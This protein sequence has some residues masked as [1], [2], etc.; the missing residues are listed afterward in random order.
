[1][2]SEQ[3]EN[4]TNNVNGPPF[5]AEPCPAGKHLG[6]LR[7]SFS[8]ATTV[9]RVLGRRACSNNKQQSLAA[10]PSGSST[11]LP[12]ICLERQMEAEPSMRT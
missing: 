7:S 8:E 9:F 4:Y 5:P 12:T 1:M 2:M 3:N 11:N 6:T 10:D